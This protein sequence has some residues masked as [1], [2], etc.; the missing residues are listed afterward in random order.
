MSRS[1]VELASLILDLKSVMGDDN[2]VLVA[3]P[4]FS[5]DENSIPME[6]SYLVRFDGSF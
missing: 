4:V 5:W 2:R 1:G 3:R 6:N